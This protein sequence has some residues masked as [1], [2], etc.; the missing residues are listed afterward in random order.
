M[1]II[2]LLT[3]T[4]VVASHPIKSYAFFVKDNSFH[5]LIS[6]SVNNDMVNIIKATKYSGS[7]P[8]LIHK[9]SI[10]FAILSLNNS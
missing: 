6:L 2:R 5:L 4:N 1:K 8:S 7:I 9:E 3:N 10:P